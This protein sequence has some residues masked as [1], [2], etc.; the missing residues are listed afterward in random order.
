MAALF[1]LRSE[2]F[3]SFEEYTARYGRHNLYPFMTVGDLRL[4]DASFTRPY[5][6]IFG[7]ESSGLSEEYREKGTAV[8]IAHSSRIDSLN[9][10]TAV[11]L[12]LYE[13][14]RSDFA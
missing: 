11:A 3:G 14:T 4:S 8:T 13:A 10:P 7:N 9:L 2:Y 1:S 12:A 6:L 5:S